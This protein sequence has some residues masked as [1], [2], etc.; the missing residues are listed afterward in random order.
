VIRIGGVSRELCGG[1]HVR[2]LGEIGLFRI[3]RE[4]SIGAGL[5][6]IEAVSGEAA[7]AR[8]RR[9]SQVLGEV[10]GILRGTWEDAPEKARQ[11][12]DSRAGL[13]KKLEDAL[14]RGSGGG[15]RSLVDQVERVGSTGLLVA[16]ADGLDTAELGKAVDDA[17][18]ATGTGV[19]VLASV[20]DRKVVLVVGVSEDLAKAKTFHAG[21]IARDMA[22]ELGG[23]GGGRPVFAQGGGQTPENLDRT[24]EETRARLR[25]RQGEER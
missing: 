16:R 3:V 6:R 7:Y 15:V 17:R 5:R 18:A 25:L 11:L 4:S 14:L 10:A 23:N 13:E 19:F 2:A 21:H 24:L 1:T 22:R 12:I 20:L 9:E 8:T